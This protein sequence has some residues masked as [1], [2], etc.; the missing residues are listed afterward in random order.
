MGWPGEGA[1]AVDDAAGEVANGVVEVI[2]VMTGLEEADLAA[3]HAGG[4]HP[5]DGD[6]RGKLRC[7]VGAQRVP[8]PD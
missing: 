6:V 1:A 7:G 8:W 3:T 4:E 5:L 2:V